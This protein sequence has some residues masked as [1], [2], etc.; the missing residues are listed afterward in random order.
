[1]M[2]TR[3]E[4]VQAIQD[5]HAGRMGRIP[6]TILDPRPGCPPASAN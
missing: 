6:A 2:N 5:Y 3:E 4:I 1:V